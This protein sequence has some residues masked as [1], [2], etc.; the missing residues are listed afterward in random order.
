M[1]ITKS[2][3]FEDVL[4]FEHEPFRD[5]RGFFTEV[6]NSSKSQDLNFNET[7]YQD[8]FSVS[9]K[10][11]LRGLHYQWDGPMGKLVTV[12]SGSVY[13]VIVDVRLGS[14][15]YGESYGI[16]LTENNHK[17]L[18]V[19]P[20][21]AHGF[22]SLENNTKVVYKCSAVYNKEGEGG[23]R[24]TE[25]YLFERHWNQWIKDKSEIIISDK[26]KNAQTIK[27][28]GEGPKFSL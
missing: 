28:Y 27:E 16:L 24:P 17:Q 9:H 18:W 2:K 22:L 23:I 21:Y 14:S 6:Y 12:F 8:N 25:E 7:F 26:D 5:N 13:D 19:P 20:G 3:K 15:T 4:I 10:G 1:K 11:V